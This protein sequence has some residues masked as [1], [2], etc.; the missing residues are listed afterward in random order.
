MTGSKTAG[1]DRCGRRP[2]RVLVDLVCRIARTGQS[3]AVYAV[4][5]LAL[6]DITRIVRQRPG[7]GH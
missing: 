7:H 1:F 4:I 6:L 2:G 3:F 5:A